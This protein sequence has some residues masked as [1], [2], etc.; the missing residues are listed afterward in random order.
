MS[1]Q[2]L[3]VEMGGYLKR[4]LFCSHVSSAQPRKASAKNTADCVSLG[5]SVP[6][7]W[8]GR[9]SGF[10]HMT[11]AL[12]TQALS[13]IQLGLSTS[14]LVFQNPVKFLL[15]MDALLQK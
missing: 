12:F 14:I 10:P 8:R 11:P 5:C 7:H 3:I 15:P 9:G 2:M 13:E 4:G 1:Y 6:S